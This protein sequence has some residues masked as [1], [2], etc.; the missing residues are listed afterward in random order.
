MKKGTKHIAIYVRVS[1]KQQDTRSQEPDL[2]HWAEAAQN[3]VPIKWYWDKRTGRK[4]DRP[5]W[6]KLEE[7]IRL[8]RVKQI[9]VWRLDRLGRTAAG[10]TALFD[11]LR[12]RKV[13]LVSLKDG[14]DLSTPA[15]RLMAN[16]L[17]SVA[18]YESEVRGERIRAGQAVAR[19]KGKKWGGSE[20]GRRW[21]VTDDQIKIVHRMFMDEV[22][23]T[24]IAKA[25]GLSL[26]TIY[27]I[28]DEIPW[29]TTLPP[30]VAK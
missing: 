30:K 14:L 7:Q 22:P 29:S 20:K 19:A 15:G 6:N 24:R 13:N 2:E 27:S 1:S 11:E 4:M 9:V 5:G 3:G 17:A 28:I 16:V 23:K 8:G 10:L 25:L 21:K 18:Q 26:P 12:E